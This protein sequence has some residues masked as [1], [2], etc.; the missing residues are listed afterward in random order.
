MAFDYK[1]LQAALELDRVSFS[2][3]VV[4]RLLEREVS[5]D[6][7]LSILISGTVIA[8]YP[9]D[10]PWPSTL[11]LGWID[12]R[13]L[14]VVAALDQEECYAAIVTVYEPTLDRFMPDFKTRRVK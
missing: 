13:P 9:D 2:K 3:H 4:K 5:Q 6:D 1:K 14:H 8:E 10:K 7:I 11:I 12:S